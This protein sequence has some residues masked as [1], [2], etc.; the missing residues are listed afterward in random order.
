[1]LAAAGAGGAEATL[2]ARPGLPSEAPSPPWDGGA[3]WPL[4]DVPLAGVEGLAGRATL[5]EVALGLRAL[6]RPGRLRVKAV[7]DFVVMHLAYQAHQAGQRQDARAAFSRGTANCEG[8]ARLVVELARLVGETAVYVPGLALEADGARPVWHAWNAVKLDGGW[9]LV[10]A[11]FDDPLLRLP[12]GA[13]RAGYRT[14]YL[15]VPPEV[16][17]LDHLPVEPRWQLLPAPLTREAFARPHAARA[18]SVRLGLRVL[19]PGPGPVPAGQL[20]EVRLANPA[21]RHVLVMLDEASCGLL[22]TAEV[23]AA[24]PAPVVGPHR[25]RVFTNSEETGLF[26]QGLS[27]ELMA[28]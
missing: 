7:H 8:Y 13:T 12:D 21:G 22:A 5:E 6:A 14:D 11:T 9:E 10:D 15:F 23:R 26:L 24:C 19:A 27:I 20:L 4:P 25:V 18:S 16:A 28:R 1:V 2:E 17:A 3:G